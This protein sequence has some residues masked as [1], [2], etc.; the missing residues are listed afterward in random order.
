M[1]R[2]IALI[3]SSFALQVMAITELEV[4]AGA[5][6]TIQKDQQIMNL[7]RLDLGDGAK[8]VFAEGVTQWQVYADKSRIGQGVVIDGRGR[9]GQEGAEGKNGSMAASCENGTDGNNGGNG[10]AGQS[11]IKLRLQLGVVSLGSLSLL[12]DGGM[13]GE[14]GAGGDGSAVSDAD[15]S[16][17]NFPRGGNAGNGG[18]GGA[19]GNGGDIILQYWPLSSSQTSQQIF[20]RIT[21]EA[22]AGV[23]GKGGIEAVAGEGSE[24]HYVTRRSLTGNRVWV[25]GGDAGQPGN[26]GQ[27]GKVGERGRVAIEQAAFNRAMQS[28]PVSSQTGAASTEEELKALKQTLQLL[29]QRVERLEQR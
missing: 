8:I 12:A 19:G 4:P 3:C 6:Y 16:C 1:K 29:I 28:L 23:G 22:N 10:Q 20:A 7:A 18:N 24:G 11:G 5:S 2:L 13:G 15:S 26:P 25:A 27:A 21:A 14:G 9:A 17:K